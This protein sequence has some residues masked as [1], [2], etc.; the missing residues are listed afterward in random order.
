M[1][2]KWKHKENWESMVYAMPVLHVFS[3]NGPSCTEVNKWTPSFRLLLL[4][5][6]PSV[7][8][9]LSGLFPSPG[10]QDQECFW[11]ISV[12][13]W[14][15]SNQWVWNLEHQ[16]ESF[17]ANRNCE[18]GSSECWPV[19]VERYLCFLQLNAEGLLSSTAPNWSSSCSS[20]SSS[21]KWLQL[22]SLRHWKS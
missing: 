8:W 3:S 1:I 22:E 9:N 6:M 11:P 2:E 14:L 15:E 18:R 13:G 19:L 5:T 20:A 16:S 12:P 10:L 7:Y 17:S 4:I 21:L